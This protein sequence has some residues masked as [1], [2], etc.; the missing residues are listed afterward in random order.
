MYDTTEIQG[1]D[2][3]NMSDLELLE[4][5]RCFGPA[6]NQADIEH[7]H[8]RFLGRQELERLARLV[9]LRGRHA[10]P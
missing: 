8:R 1:Q 2:L 3:Q 5:V 7:D 9:Q 6:E 4:Y 10:L